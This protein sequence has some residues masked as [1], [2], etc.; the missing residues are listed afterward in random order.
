MI[1]IRRELA[2]EIISEFQTCADR[3]D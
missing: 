3:R 2:K 1:N